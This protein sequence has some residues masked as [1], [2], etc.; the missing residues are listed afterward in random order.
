MRTAA[1]LDWTAAPLGHFGPAA[2]ARAA[3]QTVRK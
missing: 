2:A 3:A 1:Q